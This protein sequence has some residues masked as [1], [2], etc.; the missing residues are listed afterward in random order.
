MI[1]R[2]RWLV[3]AIVAGVILVASLVPVD[4]GTTPTLLGVGLDKWQHTAGYA[5]LAV[6]VS[7]ALGAT[8]QSIAQRRLRTVGVVVGYGVLIEMLQLPLATRLFTVTDVLA[9]TVGALVGITVISLV[10]Q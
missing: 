2:R 10:T 8:E 3:A 9:N 7:H 4:G 6:A 5:L 1:A